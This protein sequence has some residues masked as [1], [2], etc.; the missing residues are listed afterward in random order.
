MMLLAK[1]ERA[2]T[3][4]PSRENNIKMDLKDK[5]SESVFN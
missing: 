1:P 5:A 2:P 4:T 3:A